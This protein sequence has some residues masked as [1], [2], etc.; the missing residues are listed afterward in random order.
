MQSFVFGILVESWSYR[1]RWNLLLKPPAE[2]S[3]WSCWGCWSCRS[4]LQK[5]AEAHG[6]SIAPAQIQDEK[7]G[8]Y[9]TEKRRNTQ[10][11][12]KKGRNKIRWKNGL[13]QSVRLAWVVCRS[14]LQW[15][16]LPSSVA[17]L[18]ERE[19]KKNTNICSRSMT[20]YALSHTTQKE[21]QNIYN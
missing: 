18:R 1:G 5:P 11:M 19:R 13:W 17:V 4:L 12:W 21:I 10:V 14:T 3:R 16:V 7:T 20:L 6:F 9:E 2:A 8:L 15:Q